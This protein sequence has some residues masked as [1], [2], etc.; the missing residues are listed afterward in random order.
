VVLGPLDLGLGLLHGCLGVVAG[1]ADVFGELPEL[2]DVLPDE[3]GARVYE[4]GELGGW[5]ANEF[6]GARVGL[7]PP[8]TLAPGTLF[9]WLGAALPPGISTAL[10]GK[11]GKGQDVGFHGASVNGY[12]VGGFGQSVAWG[13]ATGCPW[14]YRV[15]V[16]GWVNITSG[17]IR[18]YTVGNRECTVMQWCRQAFFSPVVVWWWWWDCWGL[19]YIYS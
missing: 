4:V 16:V 1:A 11:D 2:R 3:Q 5:R 6:Q 13:G 18:P 7:V 12:T 8:E 9:G 14:A 17:Y 19:P 10:A 15:T